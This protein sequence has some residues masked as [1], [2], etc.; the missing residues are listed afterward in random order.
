[1]KTL[2]IQGYNT[3]FGTKLKISGT[4]YEDKPVKAKNIENKF[5][6]ETKKF[7]GEITIT[8]KR[9]HG[10]SSYLVLYKNG[11][12]ADKLALSHNDLYSKTPKEFTNTMKQVLNY[13]IE[14]QKT[15]E[16]I[17]QKLNEVDTLI[18]TSK[19]KDKIF[20]KQIGAVYIP[21]IPIVNYTASITEHS[22]KA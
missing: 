11:L 8:P 7:S 12:Y 6:F 19:E 4:N 2:A 10:R 22:N 18:Q 17:I 20:A 1:M 14:R 5:S 3:S 16:N 9:Q 21:E 13:F 15:T